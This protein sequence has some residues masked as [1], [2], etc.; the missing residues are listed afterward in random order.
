MYLHV[1]IMLHTCSK[2]CLGVPGT[3]TATVSLFPIL[4]Q[5]NLKFMAYLFFLRASCIGSCSTKKHMEE[6]F[7]P[8]PCSHLLHLGFSGTDFVKVMG[9]ITSPS[10]DPRKGFLKEL[11][12]YWRKILCMVCSNDSTMYLEKLFFDCL[13]VNRRALTCGGVMNFGIFAIW[14]KLIVTRIFNFRK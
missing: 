5:V 4:G 7:S 13:S 1:W 8:M 3:H 9:H 2:S 14:P 6:F 10:F 12:G 11:L